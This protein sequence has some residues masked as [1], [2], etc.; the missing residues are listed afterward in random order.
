LRVAEATQ[1]RYAL[2][3]SA[4]G[5]GPSVRL[6]A[7]VYDVATGDRLGQ[8]RV[9]GSPD[10]VLALVDQL[11][12]S[13]IGTIVRSG[14]GELPSVNLASITTTSV[15]ALKA[16]LEGEA[17]FRNANFDAAAEALERAVEADSTFGLAYYRLANTY[18]WK[19]TTFHPLTN[20]NRERAYAYADRLPERQAQMI[21]I[22]AA[23]NRLEGLRLARDAVQRY[24]DDPEA[25]YEL[26][27][28]YIHGGLDAPSWEQT[29]EA[30]SR[31]VELD[32]GFAPYRIHLIDLAMA[33]YDSALLAD[34]IAAYE[35][36]VT[37]T[38]RQILRGR[39]GIALVY[40]DSASRA[41][42]YSVIDTMESQE[43]GIAIGTVV[44]VDARAW[45]FE[46]ALLGELAE[47]DVL[48]P[49]SAARYIQ[50]SLNRGRFNEHLERIGVPGAPAAAQTCFLA[51]ADRNG[52]P[53]DRDRIEA[54]VAVA[55][56][57][58]T[59]LFANFCGAWYA[60]AAERWADHE[61]LLGR[62][63]RLAD[64]ALAEGDTS[65]AVGARELA[66]V[67]RGYA[68]ILRGEPGGLALVERL[69]VA[70]RDSWAQEIGDAY[71]AADSLRDA[72]HYYRGEWVDP[73]VRLK[74]A[75]VYE[76][77]GETDKARDA[78][79]YFV[80]A[81][82]DA[83]PELQPMVEDARQAIVRLRGD[84]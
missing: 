40:G 45:R 21:R 55:A 82:T 4:V 74:L 36:L 84:F 48:R 64:Q 80:Q 83:D 2:I 24:P 66:D 52:L 72:V 12:I 8:A 11:S 9:E 39:L 65:D 17:A 29:D 81:W 77:L 70:Q 56:I 42:A 7:D 47:R 20:Q 26:G 31:A 50:N 6:T 43:I 59:L 57:D 67:A 5:I 14:E 34:R 61:A 62:I 28:L 60:A 41:W 76:R 19:Y 15:P 79:M 16:Y 3:G 30:F 1:A 68:Q 37:G 75:R 38:N 53:I 25:W 73:L 23:R 13:V 58:S 49:W 78:Y 33:V 18:G 46:D 10:S 69:R 51:R 44:S 54:A 22:D 71:V 27:E 63:E 32:P 35:V